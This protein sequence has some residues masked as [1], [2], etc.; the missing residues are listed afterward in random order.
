MAGHIMPP[1]RPDRAIVKKAIAD[2]ENNLRKAAQLLGCSRTTLYTW[3]YQLGLDRFAGIRPDTRASVNTLGCPDTA[4]DKEIK[5]GVQTTG[6]GR[7]IL[8]VVEQ[9]PQDPEIQATFKVHESV[10]MRAKIEAIRRKV[11]L[12]AIVEGALKREFENGGRKESTK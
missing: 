11:T 4:T 7:P 9:G 5:S 1:M 6:I 3:I 8:H 2:A 12:G 10:W